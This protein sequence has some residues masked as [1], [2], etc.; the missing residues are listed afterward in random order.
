MELSKPKYLCRNDHEP[1]SPLVDKHR[2]FGNPPSPL[3]CLRRIR[4]APYTNNQMSVSL[5]GNLLLFVYF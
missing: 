4:T 3:V 5:S 2:H 1:P